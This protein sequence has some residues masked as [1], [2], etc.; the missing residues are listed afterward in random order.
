MSQS[1]PASLASGHPNA[2]VALAPMPVPPS[3][4]VVSAGDLEL[5]LLRALGDVVHDSLASS[6][7]RLKRLSRL[8]R[9]AATAAEDF[10][11]NS[12]LV[13]L[14]GGLVAHLRPWV[15]VADDA[16]S[17]RVL[18]LV[19][20]VLMLAKVRS[21]CDGDDNNGGPH[22]QQ[23]LLQDG[24][25]GEA[26]WNVE[27]GDCRALERLSHSERVRALL[28]GELPR[29]EALL[30]HVRRQE[31]DTVMAQQRLEMAPA[32]IV[33][34]LKDFVPVEDVKRIKEA[35]RELVLE[36]QLEVASL[37][38][39]LSVQERER[40]RLEQALTD[41][42]SYQESERGRRFQAMEVQYPQ[43][44]IIGTTKLS[45]IDCGKD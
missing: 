31:L 45:V 1:A 37:R 18:E 17:K 5:R 2:L 21:G 15:D 6:F 23:L 14:V 40:Q 35:N 16:V 41:V 33:M 29:L 12:R 9:A 44:A 13:A 11:A 27:S 7:A 10:A 4:P 19:V 28:T 22:S 3:K 39:Q 32:A 20:N 36:K 38:E 24:A 30:E 26:F 34:E 8:T 25:A 43:E 42:H